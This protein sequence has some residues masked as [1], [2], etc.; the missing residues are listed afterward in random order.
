MVY[1]GVRR[2]DLAHGQGTEVFEFFYFDPAFEP[3]VHAKLLLSRITKNDGT[4]ARQVA[5]QAAHVSTMAHGTQY[6]SLIHI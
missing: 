3:P 5:Y 6:L 4:E 1:K 2:M